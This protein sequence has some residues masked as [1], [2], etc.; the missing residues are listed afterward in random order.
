ML[1]LRLLGAP[2][3]RVEDAEL[4]ETLLNKDLALLFYL[5]VTGQPQPRS[6]LSVLL[7]GDANDIAARANLRKALSTLHQVFG[8]YIDIT[9]DKVGVI[10]TL[11]TVDTWAFERQVQEGLATTNLQRL[12]T[13]AGQYQGDFL[14]GFTVHNAPD[15]DLWLFQTRE[16]L[17]GLAVRALSTLALHCEQ[18]GHSA[19]AVTYLQRVLTMEPWNEEAHCSLMTAFATLGQRSAALQQYQTCVDSLA[20]ELGV[21]PDT[22]TR[23][24]YEHILAGTFQPRATTTL[25]AAATTASPQATQPQPLGLMLPSELTPIVGREHELAELGELLAQPD[26][27]LVSIV[28]P[29]GIGSRGWH[30]HWPCVSA[31]SLIQLDSCRW[32]PLTRRRICCPQWKVRCIRLWH[33]QIP[34]LDTGSPCLG[35]PS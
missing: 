34:A 5:A 31:R 20:S 16:R 25:S 3:V 32:R 26:C 19:D 18:S 6:S 15:F 17:R 35:E 33:G 1:S 24:L 2:E 7:C 8:S 13:A 30:W 14:T 4:A 22:N 10:P 23:Q 28:G 11:C 27:R 29:G 12:Q 21:E 9:R